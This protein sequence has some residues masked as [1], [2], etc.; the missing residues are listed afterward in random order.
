M[1]G[2]T[3]GHYRI[4]LEIGRGGMGVVYQA[5]D[6]T[7]A[8]PVALKI[9]PP[10]LA[11]DADRRQRFKSEALALAT[12][13][14]PHIVTV[15]SVE[16]AG[17]VHF[18][19]ME[20]VKGQTLADAL[21]A[22]GVPLPRFFE[23]AIPL[24][25]AVA[26]AHQQ[27]ITHRDLKPAN[28][29]IGVDGR[30]KVLDFGLAKAMPGEW[31]G[32]ELP[33]IAATRPGHTV[34][35]PAYMSPE[36]A[37]GE[38]VDARSDIF[39]LGIVFYELL[40][41]RR[42]FEGSNPAAV[43]SAILRDTPRLLSEVQSTVPRA[44]AR[45]VDRC[46][47]KKPADRF[48]SAIDLRHSL[49][50]VK[51]DV[52]SGDA[53]AVA[54]PAPA[55]SPPPSPMW[56]YATLA[57]VAV[58]AALAAGLWFVFGRDDADPPA[59]PQ[60]RNPV[61]LTSTFDVES[62]PTWSPD[63]ER[64][65]YQSH[66]SAFWTIGNHD[67]WVTQLGSGEP[68]NL[69]ADSPANDRRPS[70]S[71]DG[72]EIAFFS[73]RDG[74][75]GVWVVPAL[76]GG[77]KRVLGLPGFFGGS[78]W[79]A[80]QWAPDGTRL[81]VLA[82]EGSD[83]QNVVIELRLDT[84]ETSRI[85]LPE[86]ESPR[87]WD[88]SV[89]PDGRRFAYLEAGGGNPELS[90]LWT[91]A[92]SGGEALPLTDGLTNVWSPTWSS[93]GRRIFFVSNRGG[94]LDL[95]QQAVSDDGRAVG[96]P[97]AV[98]TGIGMRSAVFS[99]DGNRLAYS[100]GVKVSNVWRVPIPTDRPATWADAEQI[101]RERAY[102]EFVDVSPG[103]Q[104]LA[105]SS[106]RRG[107]QDLWVLPAAGGEMTALTTD[108]TPDW[109]PRWSPDGSQIVFYAYRS[110]NRDVWVMPARGGPAR[111]LTSHTA[112]D[113]FP[114]WSPL[115]DEIAFQS[116]RDGETAIF[117][118]ADTGGEPR[119]VATG[120][121]ADWA[122]DGQWLAVSREGRLSRVPR[123]GGEPVPMST[124]PHEVNTPR[125]SHD[126]RSIYFSVVSGPLED[127]DLWSVSLAD[128]T[129]SRLTK[130]EGRRGRLGYY[131]AADERNVYFTW[132]DDEGDIWVMDVVK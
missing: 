27:G 4:V 47:A 106:D 86:H 32:T 46:L 74:E 53:F 38:R 93:D 20:L 97:L 21:P 41:G 77:A 31:S 95:W 23:I 9:L 54:R 91:I 34:G 90:R 66:E 30:L 7:L 3:L 114:T 56:G 5:E 10:E 11:A 61:Q 48:Q 78:S 35:T 126:G 55:P 117:L 16:E 123:N 13:N 12:L 45:L 15:H 44:L 39:A 92:A 129:T 113:S 80:P 8:R 105:V 115:G 14:H 33:T 112:G 18:I 88:L 75:W 87:R 85:A 107:N 24:A 26:A 28:V 82:E 58:L 17:G 29:M 79:S 64:V 36:Q 84:L 37:Q 19:T 57:G 119:R 40:T 42:P 51:Q 101:T 59:V 22:H 99:P 110:G 118:V 43:V 65:A 49:E 63:G 25:D 1:I 102:V 130:L 125:V 52:E 121:S 76:G 103:S 128:G 50:E 73:D 131:F 124:V 109:N 96:E 94:S 70:W 132:L 127:H 67:I 60:L 108:P 89:R 72:R 122:P 81:F 111:Q 62:Y 120:G 98:T 68:R 104:R 100:R 6:T 71:P 69:T 83:R 116:L 2:Q